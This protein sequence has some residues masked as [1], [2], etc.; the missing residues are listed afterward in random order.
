MVMAACIVALSIAAKEGVIATVVGSRGAGKTTL[1]KTI[2]GPH[3]RG[4]GRGPRPRQAD[5]QG[6]CEGRLS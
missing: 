4:R 5:Q 2:L 3:T 1:P 6:Q